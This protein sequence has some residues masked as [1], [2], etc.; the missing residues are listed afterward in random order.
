MKIAVFHNLPSGGAKRALHGNI[1]YLV[2][3]HE[4]DVFVPSTANEDYLPLENIKLTY[5]LNNISI[6]ILLTVHQYQF[7][8][9]ND[10]YISVKSDK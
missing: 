1:K 8:T 4:V 3:E 6:N 10:L 5:R 2:K 9:F 7:E